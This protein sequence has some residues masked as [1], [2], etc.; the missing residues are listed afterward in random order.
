MAAIGGNDSPQWANQ[1]E[2]RTGGGGGGS[3]GDD[4]DHLDFVSKCACLGVQCQT[5]GPT[6]CNANKCVCIIF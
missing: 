1:N 2:E 4:D 3:G 6:K 5:I